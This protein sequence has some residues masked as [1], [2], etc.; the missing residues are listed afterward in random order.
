MIKQVDNIATTALSE[1]EI[2]SRPSQ[3]KLHFLRKK[4]SVEFNNLLLDLLCPKITTPCR[5][6]HTHDIIASSRV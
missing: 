2:S 1:L 4:G 3:Y 5:L 6:V